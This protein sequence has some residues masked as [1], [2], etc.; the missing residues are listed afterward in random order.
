MRACYKKLASSSKPDALIGCIDYYMNSHIDSPKQIEIHEIEEAISGISISESK[1]L[2]WWLL[3]KSAGNLGDVEREK[4]YNG[5]AVKIIRQLGKMIGDEMY[6]ES[7][8]NKFP[9]RD[10]LEG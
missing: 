7:F 9:V 5:N 8:L 6:R 4:D 2:A 3:A 10:I 1:Y